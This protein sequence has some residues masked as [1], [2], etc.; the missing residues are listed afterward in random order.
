MP[1]EQNTI[2]TTTEPTTA[3]AASVSS[4]QKLNTWIE[5]HLTRVP[6]MQKYLFIHHLQ[7]MTKAGLSIVASLNILAHE[8]ENKK[9]RNVIEQVKNDI[10]SGQQFS[11]V[12]AKYPSIFPPIYVSMI[13]AG[14]S[15]G[16]MED[17]LTQVA[18]QMNKSQRLTSKIRGAMIY[19]S[20]ILT[21]MVGIA[22]FVVFYILPKIMVMFEE[23]KVDLPL[24][25]RVLMGVTKFGQHYWWL[26]IIIIAG[27]IILG[28]RLM[29]LA[30]FKKFIH[31]LNLKI[32]IF[33]P[34]AKKINLARFTLT[35]SSLLASTIPIIEATRIAAQVLGNVIFKE[36]V[37]AT[38]ESLKQGESLSTI[39]MRYPE[40]FPPMVTEMIMV[41][42][43]SGNT[44][45]ML[46]ELAEYFNNEVE[47]TMNNFTTIIE[48]V[49][50]LALGLGVAGIAV[51]VIMP[52]YSLAQ[53]V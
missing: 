51:A 24:S 27:L 42:E 34:V 20:V 43:Q 23:V 29:K 37:M 18:N 32:P 1:D 8:V 14:E 33:G 26:V 13:A 22:I 6:F 15:A 19:P 21:A 30:K 3:P 50:I 16:K 28:N 40:T 39:L 47:N 38:A 7:I 4:I 49:I 46:S 45:K 36:N 17:A 25:T 52:M 5:N 41:G 10:E 11:D 12:L 2:S 9:L 35:L 53:N 48:P 44:E 31:S